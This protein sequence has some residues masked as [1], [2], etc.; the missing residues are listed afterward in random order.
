MCGHVGPV[1]PAFHVHSLIQSPVRGTRSIGR[2]VGPDSKVKA[3][4]PLVRPIDLRPYRRATSS[5]AFLG[6]SGNAQRAASGA[7]F[8]ALL[9]TAL[10]L[11]LLESLRQ[12]HNRHSSHEALQP[13]R[14]LHMAAKVFS[15]LLC[16]RETQPA[17]CRQRQKSYFVYSEAASRASALEA[18]TVRVFGWWHMQRSQREAE[19]VMGCDGEAMG[20]TCSKGQNS[21]APRAS[22]SQ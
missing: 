12:R 4:V 22:G 10:A 9:A 13:C 16:C 7:R 19:E 8:E 21:G 5:L 2:A 14:C 11:I 20:Q 15:T 17:R 18:W 6:T 1:P 3:L